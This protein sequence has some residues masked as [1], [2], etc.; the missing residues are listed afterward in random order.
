MLDPMAEANIER[1][2]EIDV[3]RI[4]HRLCKFRIICTHDNTL[5]RN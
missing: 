5:T 3:L 4:D 1:N 2:G